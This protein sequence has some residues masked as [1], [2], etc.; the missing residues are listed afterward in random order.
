MNDR[1]A[2]FTLSAN[3]RQ[4]FRFAIVGCLNV[5]VSF[6]GFVLC[7]E[8]WPLGSLILDISGPT[9]AL[10]RDSL[11]AHGILSVNGA[12]ANVVG[13]GVG[14]V[15]S[16]VLNKAWTFRVQ[17][18]TLRQIHRFFILNALGLLFS[19]LLIFFFVDL[20]GGPHL[21]IWSIATCIVMVL[22]FYGNKFWTFAETHRLTAS[23]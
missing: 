9:G 14:M 7:Y 11:T 12:F 23:P 3:T 13:Y 17:G 15:N 10:I 2:V 16:F 6:A 21:F 4:L 18:N 8:V 19:T 5:M 1:I 20:M 22:N